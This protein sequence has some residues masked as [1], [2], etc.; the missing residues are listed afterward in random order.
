[1]KILIIDDDADIC[2]L[3][4]KFF[5]KRGFTV[6]TANLLIDGL[7][8]IDDHQPDILF[9]DNFLPDGEGWKAVRTVK[10]KYPDIGINLMSAKDKSFNTLEHTD[11]DVIWEKPISIEQLETY[12]QFLGKNQQA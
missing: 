6:L 7:R 4:K 10:I 1:M 3:L 2:V 9:I 8:M 5:E 12:L 11:E